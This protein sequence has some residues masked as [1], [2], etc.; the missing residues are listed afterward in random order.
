MEKKKKNYAKKTPHIIPDESIPR[1]ITPSIP[2][3]PGLPMETLHRARV[4]GRIC[5]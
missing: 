1:V 3:L 5:T 2:I 4:A